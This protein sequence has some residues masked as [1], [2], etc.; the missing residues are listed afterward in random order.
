MLLVEGFQKFAGIPFGISRIFE[1]LMPQQISANRRKN[2]SIQVKV[3][4]YQFCFY[5]ATIFSMCPFGAVRKS[6]FSRI[7]SGIFHVFGGK[8]LKNF[9]FFGVKI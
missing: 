9:T 5:F 1:S 7:F 4:V 6:R 8:F 3:L 2:R